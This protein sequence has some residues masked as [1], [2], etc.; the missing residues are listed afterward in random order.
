[1]CL[2]ISERESC[3]S[4]CVSCFLCVRTWWQ[5][6]Q[7]SERQGGFHC[8]K[9]ELSHWE[10]DTGS[11]LIHLMDIL[12]IH[13]NNFNACCLSGTALCV[14]T[15]ISRRWCPWL[16]LHNTQTDFCYFVDRSDWKWT[17]ALKISWV[18]LEHAL[19]CTLAHN[20]ESE[21]KIWVPWVEN[22]SCQRHKVPTLSFTRPF[23]TL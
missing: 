17:F 13:L 8:K 21:L 18:L 14:Q 2:F 6:I 3:G 20:G 1:M 19:S 11:F 4:C 22:W 16:I 5:I 10:T 15:H 23:T 12:N 9:F 7:A